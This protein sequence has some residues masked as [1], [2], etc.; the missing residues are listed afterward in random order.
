MKHKIA[1]YFRERFPLREN[2]PFALIL[3]MGLVFTLQ[4]LDPEQP[5]FLNLKTAALFVGVFGLMLLMRLFDDLKDVEADKALFPER[6]VARG[7]IPLRTLWIMVGIL[8]LVFLG[9]NLWM[10]QGVVWFI[11]CL[12]FTWLTFRWFF[13]RDFIQK[14]LMVAFITHQPVGFLVNMWVAAVVLSN[15]SVNMSDSRVWWISFLFITPVMLWEISRKIKAKETENDYV[16]YSKILGPH[17]A[18][19][20]LLVVASMLSGGLIWAGD[21]IGLPAI[22]AFVQGGVFLAFS[23]VIFRFLLNPSVKNLIIKEASILLA[24]GALLGYLVFILISFP[25]YWAWV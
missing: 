13:A 2:L 7:L 3:M 20:F 11:V 24:F 9:I 1:I 22:H 14:R 4:L 10:P 18:A 12:G 16:T 21:L 8:H 17:L 25:I 15:S 5:I 23:V 19:Y 6:P